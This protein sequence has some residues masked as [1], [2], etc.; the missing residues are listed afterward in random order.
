MKVFFY[1]AFALGL[2]ACHDQAAPPAGQLASNDFEN[3]EGWTSGVAVPSLTTDK[4]HSGTHAV[5]VA[6]GTDFS[7]GY[8][9]LLGKTGDGKLRKIRL[10][11]WVFVPD[12]KAAT[13]L[14]TQLRDEATQ[15]DVF[16][17]GLPITPAAGKL[18]E[19]VKVEKVVTLP[20][21]A[22]YSNR[23][24]VYL[25]RKESALP[26]YLDDLEISRAD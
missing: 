15:K 21:T 14:V 4:A 24:L 25:W 10:Q 23:L 19:W 22:A 17:D 11:A 2:A 16:W 20:P 3:V 6:P 18:N 9:N 12:A 8:N 5:M 7:L 1:A 26:T 13:V